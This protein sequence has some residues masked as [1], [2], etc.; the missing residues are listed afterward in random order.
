MPID[1]TSD[2]TKDAVREFLGRYFGAGRIADDENIFAT[3]FVNSLFVMQLV[4]FV[5]R[6]LGV[7]VEDEDLELANFSSVEAIAGLVA[8]KRQ[9][10]PS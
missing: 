1:V 8:R 6:D 3:G 7:T 10:Q 5:E 2:V 4:T 9:V